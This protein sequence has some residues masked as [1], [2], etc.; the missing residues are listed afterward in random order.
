[1]VF[2]TF[3]LLLFGF[4]VF[5]TTDMASHHH[6]LSSPPSLYPLSLSIPPHLLTDN[7]RDLQNLPMSDDHPF[8]RD[9]PFCKCQ[10]VLA[11]AAKFAKEIYCAEFLQTLILAGAFHGGTSHSGS[12]SGECHSHHSKLSGVR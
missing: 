4:R 10:F 6:P 8:I 9:P 3:L 12:E 11:G 2:K 1:M 7:C 5:P